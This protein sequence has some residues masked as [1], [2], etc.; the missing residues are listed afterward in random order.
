MTVRVKCK[1]FNDPIAGISLCQHKTPQIFTE[2]GNHH[3][4][5]VKVNNSLVLIVDGIATRI[6]NDLIIYS[7]LK[8]PLTVKKLFD[9]LKTFAKRSDF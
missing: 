9:L 1:Q 4:H 2:K 3:K 6:L 8:A 7:A 5:N